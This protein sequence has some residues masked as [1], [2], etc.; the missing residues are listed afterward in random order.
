MGQS[1][2]R[3]SSRGAPGRAEHSLGLRS[4]H[5]GSCAEA[6]GWVLAP[7][8][9]GMTCAVTWGPM[10]DSLPCSCLLEIHNTF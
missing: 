10:F 8:S 4:W 3:N 6:L 1:W 9:A 5:P 2:G 7:A